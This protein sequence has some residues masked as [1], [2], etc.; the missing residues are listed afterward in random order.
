M[1]GQSVGEIGLQL[2][3]LIKDGLAERTRILNR[4]GRGYAFKL[5]IKHTAKSKKL[6]EA[7]NR[8]AAGK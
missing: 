3:K 6:I 4:Q 5:S 7:I 1:T 2:K 8:A